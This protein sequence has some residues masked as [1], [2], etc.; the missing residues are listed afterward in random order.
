MPRKIKSTRVL[1][2]QFYHQKCE[3]VWKS[4]IQPWE[5]RV[6]TILINFILSPLSRSVTNASTSINNS[7]FNHF[8]ATT[9]DRRAARL[10]AYFVEFIGNSRRNSDSS[11]EA[12]TRTDAQITGADG[13]TQWCARYPAEMPDKSVGG[14]VTRT[15][16]RYPRVHAP[17]KI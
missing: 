5:S 15:I 14:R 7:L 9:R 12:A 16:A 10:L 8:K 2:F 17:P 1:L 3:F 11:T 4:T 6:I 13:V